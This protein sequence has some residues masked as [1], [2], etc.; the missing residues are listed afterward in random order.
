VTNPDKVV[1]VGGG[2]LSQS[3]LSAINSIPGYSGRM[4]QD[5]DVLGP[6]Y[7][8]AADARREMDII[9]PDMMIAS[10]EYTAYLDYVLKYTVVVGSCPSGQV[11]R[12]DKRYLRIP[13]VQGIRRRK[14]VL[15]QQLSAVIRNRFSFP[16]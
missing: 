1:I 10:E 6:I 9:G 2:Y 13:K 12:V 16:Y 8:A 5:V 7:K 11:W 14:S 4:A 3:I 15:Y